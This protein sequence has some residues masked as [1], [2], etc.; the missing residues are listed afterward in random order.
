MAK[1]GKKRREERRKAKQLTESGAGVPAGH[2]ADEP[3]EESP[4][5]PTASEPKRPVRQ[6]R[7]KKKAGAGVRVSP[8]WFAGAGTIVAVGIVAF[9][10]ATSGSSGVTAPP[11]PT[12]EPDPRV[13]GLPIA[14]T[15]QL[16]AGGSDVDAYFNPKRLNG[17]AG[18]AIEI[19]IENVGSL[20]HNL[21]I[22]GADGQYDTSDDW[23]SDPVLITPG[24]E[25]RLVVKLDDP[26]TYAFRCSL[27]PQ[28]QFGELVLQ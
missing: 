16:E 28:V 1:K 18:E 11:R 12:A 4:P 5:A 15:L 13:E 26:G 2:G 9:L 24:D 7:K 22:A 27:H 10:V 20:S 19:L 21:T 25:G 23:V 3:P 8:W 17:P 6:K 14:A